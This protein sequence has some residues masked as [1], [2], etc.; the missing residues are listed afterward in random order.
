VLGAIVGPPADLTDAQLFRLLLQTPRAIAPLDFEL[1]GA[2]GAFFVRAIRR[3]DVNRINDACEAERPAVRGWLV[4][5]ELVAL[6]LCD[7][8]GTPSVRDSRELGAL[9]HDEL[10]GLTTAVQQQ[11][12]R[13]S[14]LYGHSLVDAWERRL[15]DGA[16]AQENRGAADVLGSCCEMAGRLFVPRPDRYFD[17]PIR[18]LTDGQWMAYWAANNH[19]TAQL[20]AR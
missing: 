14:P 6:T 10:Q 2:R 19:V 15:E 17:V 13:I 20:P 16:G 18:E 1:R 7:R 4:R 11:L 8:H 5:R 12:Q 3:L 9:D